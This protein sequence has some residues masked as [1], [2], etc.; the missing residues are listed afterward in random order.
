MRKTADAGHAR[1]AM[2]AAVQRM[3]DAVLDRLAAYDHGILRPVITSTARAAD[4]LVPWL[5]VSV[6]LLVDGRNASRAAVL[7]GWAGVLLSATVDNAVIK[8]LTERQRP[9]AGRLPPGQRRGTD[10]STSAFPSGHT[11]AAAAF[12]VASGSDVPRLQ[13]V[14]A[15]I[16]VVVAYAQVYTGRHYP[17][18]AIVGMVAGAVSGRLA[19]R[20]LQVAFDEQATFARA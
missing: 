18:D 19:R 1:H 14:L 20:V 7:R 11:G 9:D 10:P 8:P 6:G 4:L 3:D 2:G 12:A 13:P 17:S 15:G 5:A 16:A